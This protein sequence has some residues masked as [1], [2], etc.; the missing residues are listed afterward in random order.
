MKRILFILF[1]LVPVFSL[2]AQ[3]KNLDQLEMFYDQ[4]H[5][6]IVL[7]KADKLLDNPDY[8]YSVVPTFYKSLALFQLNQND[9]FRRRKKN[10]NSLKEA[11]DL[12][13]KFMREDQ[14]RRVFDA[15]IHEI[16]DLKQDLTLWRDDL[17]NRKK[18]NLANL[19]DDFILSQFHNVDYIDQGPSK[20]IADVPT[21]EEIDAGTNS[22]TRK[23]L[24]KY[25]KTLL[26]IKYRYGGTDKKGFDCSGF[27]GY[28][29][30]K[31]EIS[32][33]RRAADQYS[34]SKKIKLKDAKPGDLVFFSNGGG[35]N[36]V[37]I[38]VSN[39]GGKPIMIHA[40][41]S[42][43]ITETDIMSN[44]Y[45]KPRLKYIGRYLD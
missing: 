42:Q 31:F 32:L 7:K 15:H 34:Q 43:G 22:K 41:T 40:S 19:V 26:G 35:V 3:D 1:V 44:S 38:I 33:P 27:T 13:A 18:E 39:K 10:R 5:Y 12:W 25:S 6:K 29:F 17:R 14:G 23:N 45:W 24:I 30:K 9:A 16:I 2:K 8:D 36:H 20:E 21:V 11:I 37:G 28:V 4:E